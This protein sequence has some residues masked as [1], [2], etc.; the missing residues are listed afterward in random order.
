MKPAAGHK[1]SFA[2]VPSDDDYR[3]PPTVR[4]ERETSTS[5]HHLVRPP[6]TKRTFGR[7]P[8]TDRVAKHGRQGCAFHPNLAPPDR[9]T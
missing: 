6:C 5:D 1:A 9:F 2:Q 8:W 4:D 7:H 3:T